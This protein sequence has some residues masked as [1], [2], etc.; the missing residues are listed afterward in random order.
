MKYAVIFWMSRSF[1]FETTTT[2]TITQ[3]F[4]H[5][6]SAQSV[7]SLLLRFRHLHTSATRNVQH[8]SRISNS[9]GRRTHR[10]ERIQ[11]IGLS[12]LLHVG[13]ISALRSESLILSAIHFAQ[14]FSGNKT[15]GCVKTNSLFAVWVIFITAL[16]WRWFEVEFYNIFIKGTV[17]NVK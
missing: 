8:G 5:L 1:L 12:Q 2:T 3:Q 6:D 14:F 7:W 9:S 13:P 11:R 15:Y 16:I 10:I 17:P 4:D